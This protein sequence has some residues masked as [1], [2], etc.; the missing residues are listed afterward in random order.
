MTIVNYFHEYE[1]NKT[2]LHSN[3]N[4][5]F[6]EDWMLQGPEDANFRSYTFVDNDLQTCGFSTIDKLRDDQV[7]ERKQW[8]R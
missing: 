6:H 3:T 2:D 4:D 7:G 8:R 1:H 5:A